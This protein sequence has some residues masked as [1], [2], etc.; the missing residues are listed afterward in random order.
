MEASPS[1]TDVGASDG[2]HAAGEKGAWELAGLLR[3]PVRLKAIR[4]S[5]ALIDGHA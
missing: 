2:R 4:S 1:P 5:G 3:V